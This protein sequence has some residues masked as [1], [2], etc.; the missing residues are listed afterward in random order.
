M[1]QAYDCFTKAGGLFFGMLLVGEDIDDLGF[2]HP[3]G[4]DISRKGIFHGVLIYF[5][6]EGGTSVKEFFSDKSEEDTVSKADVWIKKNLYPE[7]VRG[8]L[9]QLGSHLI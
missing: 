8:G 7:Y 9:R 1:K 3:V 2:F 4:D 6:S 5:P